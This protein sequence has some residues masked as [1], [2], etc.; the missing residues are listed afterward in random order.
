MKK[1]NRFQYSALIICCLPIIA[2]IVAHFTKDYRYSEYRYIYLTGVMAIY[3]L[4]GT[5]VMWGLVNS[6]FIWTS[7]SMKFINKLFWI[8]VSLLPILI[9]ATFLFIVLIIPPY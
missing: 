6:I 5:S 3:L 4:W 1:F 9:I 8:F 7:E 2:S